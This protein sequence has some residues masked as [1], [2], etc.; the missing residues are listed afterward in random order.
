VKVAPD[1]TPVDEFSCMVRPQHATR[2]SIGVNRLTGIRDEDLIGA[3]PLAQVLVEFCDWIGEGRS[4]IVTWSPQD[5][6]QMTLECASKEIV[7]GLPTR[8]LDI[9]R[10]YPRLM[11]TKKRLIGLGEAADWCGI[12]NDRSSAHRALYDARMTAEIFQM[13]ASGECSDQRRRLDEEILEGGTHE[14]C[15]STVESL[16]AGLNELYLALK[17]QEAAA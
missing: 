9:Q 7:S 15:T 13:M 8:W 17:A 12:E 16:C 5:K 3:K 10:L 14:T 2:V 6:R 4:R 1:G 11:G